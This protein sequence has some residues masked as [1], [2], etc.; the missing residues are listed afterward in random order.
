M[1][2]KP[3]PYWL[4]VIIITTL[5]A[6]FFY[7]QKSSFYQVE[8]PYSSDGQNDTYTYP[9][10]EPSDLTPDKTSAEIDITLNGL[11]DNAQDSFSDLK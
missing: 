10:T 5:I 4:I 6:L 11:D 2:R 3:L 8:T 9:T 1:K 7:F